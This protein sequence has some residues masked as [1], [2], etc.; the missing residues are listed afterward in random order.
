MDVGIS[1]LRSASLAGGVLYITF[2]VVLFIISSLVFVILIRH[3]EFSTVTY[4]IIKNMSVACLI[5]QVI[6]LLGAVMT[7]RQDNLNYILERIAGSLI[8]YA[9]TLYMS[10]NVTLAIDRMLTFVCS[11]LSNR[12]SFI[13]IA[14]SHLHASA[15]F[16]V[17]LLPNF[18]EVYCH[19]GMHCFVWFYEQSKKGSKIIVLFEPW[20]F[21]SLELI[22]VVCYFVVLVSLIRMRMVSSA[23]K[24][25]QSYKMEIRILMVSVLSFL[26]EAGLITFLFWG[27]CFMPMKP[28]SVIIINLLWMFDSG[29]FTIATIIV[30]KSIRSKFLAIL[31]THKSSSKISS[32]KS[33]IPTEVRSARN[34]ITLF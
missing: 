22:N 4:R 31:N 11:H 15:H 18:G 23:R 13:L 25:I 1:D 7:L 16:V 17:L 2:S 8:Q 26:Y 29:V 14:M 12:V 28:L 24:Q 20:L 5:Q 34:D 3:K 21:L 27:I 30:N 6:F 19:K 9:W 10:L 33:Q 32:I